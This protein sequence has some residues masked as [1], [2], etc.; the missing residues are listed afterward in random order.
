MKYWDD[1]DIEVSDTLKKGIADTVNEY[2]GYWIREDLVNGFRCFEYH[3]GEICVSFF[4]EDYDSPKREQ[5]IRFPLIRDLL[6]RTID[7]NIDDA[8]LM[9]QLAMEFRKAADMIEAAE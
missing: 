5:T 1:S 9:K 3:N 7:T 8:E 4:L 6:N 2:I